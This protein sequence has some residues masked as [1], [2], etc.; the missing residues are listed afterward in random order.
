MQAGSKVG[1]LGEAETPARPGRVQLR[2]APEA[3]TWGR[4]SRG[5]RML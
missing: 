1:A 5:K 4:G 3:P 2:P